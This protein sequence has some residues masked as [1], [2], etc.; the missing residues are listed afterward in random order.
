MSSLIEEWELEYP[1]ELLRKA[2]SGLTQEDFV[3]NVGLA[4]STYRR[5]IERET[6]PKL[7][8]TQIVK[9][10]EVCRITP[11]EL[12]LFLEGR[13]EVDELQRQP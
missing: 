5:W 2:R 9:I 3:K 7:T 10:C 8:S 13:L 11:N 12:I 4:W 6:P 1:M